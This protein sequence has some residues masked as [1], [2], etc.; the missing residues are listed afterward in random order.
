MSKTYPVI[1]YE[2]GFS[3]LLFNL[4]ELDDRARTLATELRCIIE[5]VFRAISIRLESPSALNPG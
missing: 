5:Q 4:A 2:K 3:T 1:A